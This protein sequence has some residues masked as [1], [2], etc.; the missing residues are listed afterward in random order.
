MRLV[1]LHPCGSLHV[2]LP[3]LQHL[4]GTSKLPLRGVNASL[5][6]SSSGK[7]AVP[8]LLKQYQNKLCPHGE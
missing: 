8:T 6:D 1:N 7:T 2:A 4:K 3:F 5:A